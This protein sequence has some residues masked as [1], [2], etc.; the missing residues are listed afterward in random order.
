MYLKKLL[1]V[2]DD[3][4]V[5]DVLIGTF[6][7]PY[8][9]VEAST[10]SDVMKFPSQSVDLAIIDYR[11]PD[12]DGFEVLHSLREK[13]PSLP[14]IFM[15]GY[16]NDEVIIHALRK[17]VADFVKKPLDLKYLRRR[18]AEILVEEKRANNAPSSGKENSLDSI[19]QHIQLNYMEELTLEKLSHL[20][21]M[22]RFSFCRAFKERF[23]QC[24]VSYVNSIRMK[25]AEN[26]LTESRASITEI[27]FSVGYRNSGHFNRVFKATYKMSPRAYRN[28]KYMHAQK[29]S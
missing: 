13:R 16:S 24:F 23:R 18:V 26:L 22:S 5:R 8:M 19:A 28:K 20:A 1:I 3:S 29:P 6:S 12:R 21:G 7:G 11:L 4:M 10:Y 15:T 27:A 9:V 17:Q 25:N 14:V 2:D